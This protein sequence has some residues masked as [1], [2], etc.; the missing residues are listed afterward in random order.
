MFLHAL[1]SVNGWF[2][3]QEPYCM[4]GSNSCEAF[5]RGSGLFCYG[6]FWLYFLV[7]ETGVSRTISVSE[8][9]GNVKKY[10]LNVV[11]LFP[12]TATLIFSKF[13]SSIPVCKQST[14][15]SLEE[16]W[17]FFDTYIWLLWC[18]YECNRWKMNTPRAISTATARGLIPFHPSFMSTTSRP[19]RLHSV[20]SIN[21][22][23]VFVF[24]FNAID[25]QSGQCG[26]LH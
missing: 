4:N 12:S 7:L 17:W 22:A 10:R 23:S 2:D 1:A 16:Y 14:V 26:S 8:P 5:C 24:V 6:L 19:F 20:S 3:R 11:F 21:H 13:N 18:V 25:R 9:L 15:E